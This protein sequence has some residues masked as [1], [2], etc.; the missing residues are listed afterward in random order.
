MFKSASREHPV[1]SAKIPKL[2]PNP[3]NLSISVYFVSTQL[4]FGCRNLRLITV[5]VEYLLASVNSN[6]VVLDWI[7]AFAAS[8]NPLS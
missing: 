1:I 8:F 7:K 4:K 6:G 3:A 2:P 5:S